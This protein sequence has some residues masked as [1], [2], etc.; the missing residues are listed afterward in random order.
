MR[1]IVAHGS[2]YL[3]NSCDYIYLRSC[4]R[5]TAADIILAEAMRLATSLRCHESTI[6]K[7]LTHDFIEAESRK[8]VFWL[9][10]ASTHVENQAHVLQMARIEPLRL[11]PI[12]PC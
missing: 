8:R 7:P 12:V 6:G 1:Q 3:G 9:I 11:S 2:A 10:C 4:D 5:N